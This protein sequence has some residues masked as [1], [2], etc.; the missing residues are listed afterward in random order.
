MLPREVVFGCAVSG[1]Q[2]LSILQ[3]Y[4]SR[5]IASLYHLPALSYGG[6]AAQAISLDECREAAR[7]WPSPLIDVRIRI[8]QDRVAAY[9]PMSSLAMLSSSHETS[10]RVPSQPR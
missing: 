1:I 7:I 4:P 10:G 3:V 8:V 5:N 6:H 9:P 2:V